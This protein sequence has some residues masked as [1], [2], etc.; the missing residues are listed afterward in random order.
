MA[1]DDEDDMEWL[2]YEEQMRIPRSEE[3]IGDYEFPHLERG[4]QLNES[5]ASGVP[6]GGEVIPR[7]R[8]QQQIQ[9]RGIARPVSFTK[10][11]CK[12]HYLEGHA[13]Y[14]P[15]CPF[16]TR[17]RGLADRHQRKRDDVD[18]QA[19]DEVEPDDV[20]TISFEICFSCRRIKGKTS[21]HWSFVTII[22]AT[23]T[24]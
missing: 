5:E 21:R 16:C 1:A 12:Q 11:Q 8:R 13:N 4:E 19:G 14:H 3:D 6:V 24:H 23:R 2:N 7:Q 20:P 17:C 10:T 9:V 18:L 15:V 22:R